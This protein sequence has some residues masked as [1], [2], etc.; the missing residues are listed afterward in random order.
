MDRID[1]HRRTL[2]HLLKQRTQFGLNVPSHIIGQIR[3]TR[4]E[5][6]GLR[7]AIRKLGYEVTIIAGID[8][9]ENAPEPQTSATQPT[10]D[11]HTKLDQI[12]QLIREIRAAL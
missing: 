1:I 4:Q 5:I 8:D 7:T 6:T 12:E 11:L 10:T 2:E 3:S 9:D